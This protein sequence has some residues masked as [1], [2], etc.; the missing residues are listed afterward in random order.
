MVSKHFDCIFSVCKEAPPGCSDGLIC[1]IFSRTSV[2][3]PWGWKKDRHKCNLMEASKN[4][5]IN[6][7]KAIHDLFLQ[8]SPEPSSKCWHG[9]LTTT[10]RFFLIASLR[11]ELY[12]SASIHCSSSSMGM[13]MRGMA[14]ED[15]G[16]TETVILPFCFLLAL[17]QIPSD[18]LNLIWT[19]CKKKKKYSEVHCCTV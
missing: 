5:K 3:T 9:R 2:S 12:A 6:W 19:V 16:P 1:T 14:M 8:K 13:M 18:V 15:M 7:L 10:F 4:L 17:L 11:F